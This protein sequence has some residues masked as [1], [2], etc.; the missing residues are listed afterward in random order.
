MSKTR[1]NDLSSHARMG[2]LS[3]RDM[4][5]PVHELAESVS[6]KPQTLARRLR[7]LAEEI[8]YEDEQYTTKIIG[9]F[10]NWAKGPVF[11]KDSS[12]IIGDVQMPYIDYDL[13]D[14]MLTVAT[15]LLPKGQRSLIIAGDLFTM[16]MFS[17]YVPTHNQGPTFETE[18][19]FARQFIKDCAKVFD[20]GIHF[21]MG[22]HD[23]RLQL[24]A[25]GQVSAKNL[26]ELIAGNSL[27]M[28]DHSWIVMVS[29]GQEWRITHQRNYSINAQTVGV[30]LAHKFGQNI[31]TH[32]Q[33]RMSMGYDT[34]GKFVVVD[35]G[36]LADPDYLDY[37]N[38]DDTTSP[39]MNQGFSI[40]RNGAVTLFSKDGVFTDWDLILGKDS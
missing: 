39:A 21:V 33:H 34:S 29:G 24:K 16:D 36:C 27:V 31:M 9:G 37:A 7:E 14:R 17:K 18:L 1:W 4:G 10:T 6:M 32:H 25:F 20:D 28:H 22:N 26:G 8:R 13:A 5:V 11:K 12:V 23:R 40:I 3:E 30:K 15:K 35:N 38:I 2:L 19:K